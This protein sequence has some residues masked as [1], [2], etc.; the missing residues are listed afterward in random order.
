MFKTTKKK[1]VTA[2]T[3]AIRDIL[4]EFPIIKNYVAQCNFLIFR[5]IYA[6]WPKIFC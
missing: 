2:T 5:R 4:K 6:F 3:T 1:T